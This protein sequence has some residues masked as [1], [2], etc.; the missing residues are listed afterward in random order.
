MLVRAGLVEAVFGCNDDGHQFRT[1]REYEI[2]L[3]NFVNAFRGAEPEDFIFD[4]WA[5]GG[6]AIVPT[7]EEG[8]ICIGNIR[9]V[10]RIV[11]VEKRSRSV[12]VVGT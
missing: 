2:Q 1:G 8:S 11:T 4:E 6:E 3:T 7:M 12:N 10:E 9:C 5:P